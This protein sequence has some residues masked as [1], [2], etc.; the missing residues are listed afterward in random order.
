MKIWIYE[1]GGMKVMKKMPENI[2]KIIDEFIVGVNDILGD[3]VKKIILF[4][5]YARRRF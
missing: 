3:R 1:G 2:N 4:G 5:S